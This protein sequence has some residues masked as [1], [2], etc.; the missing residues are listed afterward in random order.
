MLKHTYYK[1]YTFV[2]FELSETTINVTRAGLELPRLG[3]ADVH[4]LPGALPGGDHLGQT[5]SALPSHIYIYIYIYIYTYTHI[6]HIFIYTSTHI[7]MCVYILLNF[8]ILYPVGGQILRI[9]H[10]HVVRARIRA[11]N[12]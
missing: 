11:C 5:H 3:G 12:V 4:E 7:Y 9:M 8:I 1:R 10:E 6:K 2:K